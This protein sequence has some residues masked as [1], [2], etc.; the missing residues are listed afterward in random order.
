M[1]AIRFESK[2]FKINSWTIL[3]LPKEVS[4]K[5]PSRG[6][7]MVKG[8]IN[9]FHFQ[10]AL[11]PDGKFSH[12]LRVDET[13]REATNV[14][15]GDTAALEIEPT[16]EWPEPNVPEDLKNA[17]AD[18][19][20][21]HKLWMDITP[22]ARWDWIRWIGSTQ[23]PQTRKKR[24]ETAFSKLKAGERRPCCFNRTACTQPSV[25]HNGVL[26]EPTKATV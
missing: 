21:I 2:L 22:M 20:P 4:A 18:V 13:M 26:L 25:S 15:A 8:T 16:K 23:N 6:Q 7:T 3:R 14:A 19:P 5:L 17:L 9:G 1:S 12:W 24:I 10:T 11:E